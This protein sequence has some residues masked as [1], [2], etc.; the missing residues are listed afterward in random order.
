MQLLTVSK[1]RASFSRVTR[2]VLKNG[3][4]VIVRTP[5]GL[6]QIAP[7]DLAEE[8]PPAP[9]NSLKHLPREIELSNTFGDTL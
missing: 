3:K 5:K 8:V 6:V 9:S 4:P 1:A 2:G 7:Y